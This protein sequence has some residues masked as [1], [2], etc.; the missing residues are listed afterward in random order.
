MQLSIVIPTRNRASQL[1]RTLQNLLLQTIP[2]QDFEVVVVDNDSGDE[3]PE[4]LR[5]FG[6]RFP[7]WQCFRQPKPGAAAARNAGIASCQGAIVL[8]IDDDVIAEP[9]LV[10][11][12]LKSHDSHP[13]CAV[14][15]RVLNGWNQNDS[16]FHWVISQKELLHSFRF[17]DSSNVPF[18]HLYT[19]NAS[20]PRDLLLKAGLFDEQFA[21]AAFE[22][23][24]LGYR[25]MRLGCQILFNPEATVLHEPVLSLKSFMRKRFDAGAALYRLLSKHPELETTMLPSRLRRGLRWALGWSVSPLPLIFDKHLPFAPL[26]F[27]VLGKACWYHFEYL[28]WTGYHQAAR[29]EDRT[30]N[31]AVCKPAG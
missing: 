19:C 27:P 12:H 31:T 17:P 30:T 5:R 24:D 22:D 6:Q 9:D 11:Q 2:T 14:L 1:E 16:A 28:F 10:R 25:L 29:S 23:T 26:L 18:Q 8:F 13:G 20:I 15:G 7:N 21:G 3:T 4:F